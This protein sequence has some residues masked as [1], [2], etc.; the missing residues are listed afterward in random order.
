MLLLDP[1]LSRENWIS[2]K[3]DDP[4]FRDLF[5]GY[6]S[7]Y[8]Q[9]V[10]SLPKIQLL[11]VWGQLVAGL[12]DCLV[13]PE[14]IHVVVE[15]EFREQDYEPS[16][17]VAKLVV[18]LALIDVLSTQGIPI[19]QQTRRILQQCRQTLPQILAS[20]VSDHFGVLKVA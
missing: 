5:H 16:S 2:S 9:A 8:A 3:P 15:R 4:R 6:C 1:P 20:A 17:K 7:A 14:L 11:R 18:L 10:L 12:R 19:R 13:G